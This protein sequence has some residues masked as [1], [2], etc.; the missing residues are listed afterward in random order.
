MSG[1]LAV[2]AACGACAALRSVRWGLRGSNHH[3]MSFVDVSHEAAELFAERST[4]AICAFDIAIA[5]PS[6]ASTSVAHAGGRT[7]WLSPFILSRVD[8]PTHT[9]TPPPRRCATL[10][11]HTPA[12]RSHGSDTQGGRPCHNLLPKLVWSYAS[13]VCRRIIAACGWFCPI[14]ACGARSR[15]EQVEPR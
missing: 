6:V 15:A 12:P 11:S 14:A 4:L 9:Y 5:C 7:D 8:V 10:V 1:W 13:V 2:V 3:P